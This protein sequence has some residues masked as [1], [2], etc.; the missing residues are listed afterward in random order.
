MLHPLEVELI[1]KE[2][3]SKR[4][5]RSGQMDGREIGISLKSKK[6]SQGGESESVV[7]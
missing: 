1:D 7:S 6:G 5:R 3:V 2:E 4:L